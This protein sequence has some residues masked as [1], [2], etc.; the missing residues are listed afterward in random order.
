MSDQ[1][2]GL[3]GLE[4]ALLVGAAV[5]FSVGGVVWGGAA[6]S[7]VVAGKSFDASLVDAIHAAARLPKH[8]ADPSVAWQDSAGRVELPGH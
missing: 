4:S 5:T 3:S 1:G 8:V 6:L 2:S 7:A